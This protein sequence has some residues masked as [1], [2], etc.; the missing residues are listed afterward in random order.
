[1]HTVT[2]YG[3][4][5]AGGTKWICA[6]AD[7][8]GRFI[9]TE[10]IPTTTPA[11]TIDGAVRFFR[12]HEPPAALGIGS[13]GP[14]DLRTDSPTYGH[15]TTTPKPGWANTDV[16]SAL[17]AALGVPVRFDLD[18]N[19]AALGEWRHG[20]GAGLDTFCYMTVGTGIGVGAVVNGRI[21]YGLLHPEFGHT[22][23]P[24]D[25]DRDPYAGSC[26]YHGDCLEGLASGEAMRRRWGCP[27][28]QIDDPK[29]WDLEAD[30]LALAVVNLTYA[31]SPERVVIGGGVAKHPALLPRVRARVLDL[32]AG[33]LAT[34]A[35]TEPAGMDD[36]IVGPS[37][38]DRSGIVGA[39]EFA[40]DALH[41]PELVP[42][43]HPHPD[44]G[45][46]PA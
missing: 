45:P 18:V 43:P 40:R 33:Y 25:L 23:L 30:Y 3:A 20:A 35:L 12:G 9:A 19:A 8:A 44:P 34:P 21:L 17:R 24:H 42:G 29:A 10:T 27:A 1:M 14:V 7:A 4:I 37:L 28:E 13:F 36:Y 38:G 31:L 39:V 22:L 46:S 6:I 16:V 11:E 41:N 26:P 2:I 15:I 5:E 32:L